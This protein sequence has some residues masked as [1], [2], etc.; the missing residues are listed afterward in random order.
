MSNAPNYTPAVSFA[1]EETNQVAGRSTVRTTA[2][3]IEL[4]NIS[5]SIN[6]LNT[7]I[8]L[9]QR[10]DG[11]PKDFI[12]EPYALSEQTRALIS[13]GGTPKGI[14]NAATNY[15]VGDSVTNA[16][17]AYLCTV[18]HTSASVFDSNLWMP[19][20]GDGSSAASA[21]AAAASATSASAS[22]TSATASATAAASSATSASGSATTATT[23]ATEATNSA[24]A[25]AANKTATDS[26]VTATANSATA[27]A[28][29]ATSA[30]GSA[31]TATTKAGE[32]STSATNAAASATSASGSAT[33]ASGSATSAASSASTATTQAT[34][35]S[36]SA[37]A[38]STSATNAAT[39]ETNAA[40]SAASA[41][42][43]YDSFDDRYLGVKTADPT[44]DN[45]GNALLTGALYFNS[46]SNVM[47]V[48]NSVA[49][50]STNLTAFADA[51]HFT[52]PASQAH[53]F[54]KTGAGTI[55]VLAGVDVTVAGTLVSFSIQTAVVMPSLTAGTD[56]AIYV[57]TDGTI[58]ADASF[59]APTGYTTANSRQIGGFHYAPGGNAAAQAGGNTT[60]AIN[61]YS[62]WDLKFRPACADPRGM[63]LIAGSFWADIYLLGVDYLTNGSSKYN[64]S[65]ADGS[66][67]PKRSTLYGGNGT[68]TYADGN[69]W[70][71]NEALKHVGKRSPTYSEFAAFAYGTTEATSSG[72]T[73]VPTTGVTGT[74]ATSAWNLF[75]S[76]FGIIQASGCMWI[77]GDEFG[78]GAAAAGYVANTQGRGST[79]QMENAVLL[80]GAWSEAATSGSRCSSWSTSAT[81]SA[82][83][84]GARGVCDHL[85]LV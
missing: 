54:A 41:A 79:Y 5:S 3:D 59:S 18:S 80:G 53:C 12:I 67:P 19:I 82:V 55:S 66:A 28:A 84:I 51:L 1:T 76:K 77:W 83:L 29:S 43:S 6:A 14:W 69:W 64:V 65:I 57:C 33:S 13:A 36:S 35:A 11:K 21:I 34:N 22:A 85:T 44:L 49:W 23:K 10:D 39:S 17:I 74:G 38:A 52:K 24:T 75:T 37:T 26:N 31:S 42:L 56:Y 58:R 15:I 46:V 8:K 78:G 61:E 73:D 63:A 60:P 62:I 16:G 25:A 48:Y 9:L 68:T 72:G 32:A 71:L 81:Y 50:Q 30:S 2:V 4:A 47:R 27:A 20:S 45:D 70:N 40:A 7:N